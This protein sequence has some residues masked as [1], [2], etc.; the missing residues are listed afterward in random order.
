MDQG[1]SL[2][3]QVVGGSSAVQSLG[4]VHN[5]AQAVSTGTNAGLTYGAEILA[6]NSPEVAQQLASEVVTKTLPEVAAPSVM[7][8]N[9]LTSST[10]S[11]GATQQ[12]QL[13]ANA[14]GGG[15]LTKTAASGPVSHLDEGGT[16]AA[17]SGDSGGQSLK[18]PSD[19]APKSLVTGQNIP[20]DISQIDLGAKDAAVKIAA[21]T[22][23]QTQTE[24]ALRHTQIMDMYAK[25]HSR[26]M[27]GLVVQAGGMA[28]SAWGASQPTLAEKQDERAMNWK[29][30][31]NEPD[32][33]DPSKY[34]YPQLAEQYKSGL[35]KDDTA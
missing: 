8:V 35:L 22:Y 26:N 32:I 27:L 20:T 4:S 31:G 16:V 9:D 24:N 2:A 19:S 1:G 25:Q 23:T 21:L 30:T 11:G 34:Q 3:S 6:G 12:L 15:L 17:A 10:V 13:T 7:P 29:P 33:V 18:I 28:A 14:P 5:V